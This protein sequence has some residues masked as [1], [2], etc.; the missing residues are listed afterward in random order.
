M[1][2]KLNTQIK[3][4]QVITEINLSINM[5]NLKKIIS[6]GYEYKT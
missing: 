6:R 3:V 5:T 2:E 1:N 4:I